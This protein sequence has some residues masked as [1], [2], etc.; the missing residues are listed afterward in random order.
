MAYD[1]A[2]QQFVFGFYARGWS[3]ERALPE[4]RKQ[5]AGFAKSTWEKW[6][7]E[8][9]WKAR[10]AAADEKARAFEEFLAETPRVMVNDLEETRKELMK[11]IRGGDT[12]PQLLFALRDIT[13]Q[14]ASIGE[15]Y[16][17]RRDPVRL[18]MEAVTGLVEEL[19]DGL[20][21][22]D[23]IAPALEAHAAQVAQLV[24]RVAEKHV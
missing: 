8:Y 1:A 16:L 4:I 6:E 21:R 18:R 12:A 10:R 20:K 23:G 15:T 13:A 2:A 24:E 11:R 17:T 7:R 19:L 22:V 14:I 3:C 9:D 5:Y